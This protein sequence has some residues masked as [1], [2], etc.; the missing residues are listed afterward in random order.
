VNFILRSNYQGARILGRLTVFRIAT[1]AKRQGYHCL[2]SART[3]DKGKHHGR[4]D[5]NKFR[6][7]ARCQP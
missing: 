1:T 2:Y 4:V 3:T 6:L 5:Y 7:R